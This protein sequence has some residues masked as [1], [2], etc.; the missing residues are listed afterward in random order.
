MSL[1]FFATL[2]IIPRVHPHQRHWLDLLPTFWHFSFLPHS[3]RPFVAKVSPVMWTLV[4]VRL[5]PQHGAERPTNHFNSQ[6]LLTRAKKS[7][8]TLA[9]A[10]GCESFSHSEGRHFFSECFILFYF[11]SMTPGLNPSSDIFCRLMHSHTAVCGRMQMQH[12]HYYWE[13]AN[14]NVWLDL[15]SL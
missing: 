12:K 11:S 15:L 14:C 13:V 1:I 10:R 5:H 2:Q 6:S 7:P 8:Q 3:L 9:S 4:S